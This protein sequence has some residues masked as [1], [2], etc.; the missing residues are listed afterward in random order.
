MTAQEIL[1]INHAHRTARDDGQIWFTRGTNRTIRNGESRRGHPHDSCYDCRPVSE[2]SFN[3]LR[4]V[5]GEVSVMAQADTESQQLNS[6]VLHAEDLVLAR[7][8]DGT[9]EIW[10][11]TIP[12]E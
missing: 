4:T 1:N 9:Y 2:I 12:D 6:F 8:E 3:Y 7:D 11:V 10:S 5:A